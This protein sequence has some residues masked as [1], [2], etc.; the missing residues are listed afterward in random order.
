[1]KREEERKRRKQTDTVS[2]RM[3]IIQKLLPR[4]GHKQFTTRLCFYSTPHR[5]VI[6]F[7]NVPEPPFVLH[8]SPHAR[9]PWE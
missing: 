5:T 2:E 9:L 7:N 8:A 4:H 3:A 1:M 6:D